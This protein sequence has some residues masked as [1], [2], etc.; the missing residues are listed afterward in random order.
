VQLAA[1]Y[2]S[3]QAFLDE[4]ILD[5]PVS[6]ADLAGP[7]LKDEDWLV[8]STIHSAKGLEWDA[9][10]L[11][12]AADGCLPSDM[13]TGSK[14]EIDEELRLTYVA[15]TRARD[16]LYVLWPLRFYG[17]TPGVTDRHVFA[18]RSR[19]ITEEVAATMDE[20]AVGRESEDGEFTLPPDALKNIGE[21]IRDI[22]R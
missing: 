5:P 22:W 19:F 18:Q 16:F 17:R 8:L 15:M 12:H 20:R 3:V 2:G 14:E 6:T 7:P 10:Y 1:G 9:V 11:I 13:S 4:L 21:R